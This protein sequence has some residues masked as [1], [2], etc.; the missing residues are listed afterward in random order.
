MLNAGNELDRPDLDSNYGVPEDRSLLAVVQRTG[1]GG[2]IDAVAG[3]LKGDQVALV[4]GLD[5]PDADEFV[6]LVAARFGLLDQLALQASF[7]TMHGHRENVGRH[8]MTVNRRDEYQFIPSHSEGSSAVPIQLAAFYCRE[9]TTDGGDTVLMN[10]DSSSLQWLRQR[11]LVTRV[12]L[13]GF[14]P[15][16][17]D[18]AR[19]RFMYSVNILKDHA[20]LGDQTLSEQPSFMP[21]VRVRKVLA[22]ARKSYSTIL[23]RHV[24][25]YWDT[26]ASVD[27]DSGLEYMKML[28]ACGLLKAPSSGADISMLDNAHKRRVWRSG[29]DYLSLFKAK[30]TRKLAP[31]ELII[32]NNTT[33]AHSNSNWTPGSGVRS[34][35]GAFA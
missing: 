19:A 5:Q 16:P 31:G 3:A 2:D 27:F 24:H 32:L 7:A 11:E 12:D 34:V 18:V 29:V 14:R 9:N 17:S 26:L 35:V 30:L 22:P 21:G 25:V 13:G 20:E 23:D 6:S 33:W 10:T 15:S 1:G 28:Q 4:Q 8:F